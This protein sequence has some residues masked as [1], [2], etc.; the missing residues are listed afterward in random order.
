MKTIL[1]TG[2]AG[3]VGKELT[4]KLIEKGHR[5]RV[6]DLPICDFS[7]LE[8]RPQVEIHTGD[9][10][11]AEVVRKAVE[12][13]DMV[14]HL[15][16]ILPPASEKDRDRTF[17]INFTGTDNLVKAVQAAGGNC[18]L[19]FSSTVATYGDTTASQPPIGVDHPQNPIDIY[20]ESKVAA[21][22]SILEAHIP[23]TIL[24]IAAIVIPALMDPPDPY[25]FMA[26]QRIEMVCRSDVITA[27]LN[28]LDNSATTDKILN[29][30]GGPSWQMYGH[31]YVERV[32]PI[33]DIPIEDAHYR[34][35]PGWSDWYDTEESQ[36]L[37]RYQNTPFE[38]YLEQLEKAVLEAL[39]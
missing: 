13:T 26:D 14:L 10:R 8:N 19:I 16:A 33:L 20:G 35:T 5:V 12:G 9:I 23:Y 25:P 4:L 27:L 3:S 7:D 15:A 22:K 11:D 34:E 39:G 31:E 18:R 6:F 36:A 1:I 32:F 30:A 2:G 24:R 29:I 21:E 28:A 37:L 17:S 38:L